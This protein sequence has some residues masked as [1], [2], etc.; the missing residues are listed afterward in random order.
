MRESDMKEIAG[1]IKRVIIDEEDTSSVKKDV[2]TFKQSF[3]KVKYC[4][5]SEA[6]AYEY[7]DIE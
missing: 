6:D 1:F 3:K 5:Q 2:E 7:F 4:F